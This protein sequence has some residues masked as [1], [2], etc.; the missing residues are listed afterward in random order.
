MKRWPSSTVASS[1]ARSLSSPGDGRGRD[2][3]V[4]QL[5]PLQRRLDSS[6]SERAVAPSVTFCATSVSRPP[7]WVSHMPSRRG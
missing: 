1:V 4:A 2:L 6:M 5:L 3:E 7:S